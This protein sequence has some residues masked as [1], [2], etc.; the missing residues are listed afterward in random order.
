MSYLNL[1]FKKPIQNVKHG[2]NKL[3]PS[4]FR[5]VFIL[6][7][8]SAIIAISFVAFLSRSPKTTLPITE[9]IALKTQPSTTNKETIPIPSNRTKTN[10]AIA[11]VVEKTPTTKFSTPI[12]EK[13]SPQMLPEAIPLIKKSITIKNGDTL[14]SAFNNQGISA[15]VLYNVIN[16][17]KDGRLLKSIRQGEKFDFIFKENKLTKLLY[18]PDITQTYSFSKDSSGKFTSKLNTN[19][20]DATPVYREGVIESSLFVAAANSNI[21]VNIIMNMVGIFGWDIDFSL[22]IRKGDHF[23]IIY[24]ELYQ[25]GVKIKT[26]VILAAE[27]TNRGKTYQAVLYTD[28]KND[29]NYYSPDGKSMRKAFLRN[30]VKFSRISSRFTT[31]RWHPVLSKWRSHKGVDYAA[32]RGT[33]IYAAGDGKIIHAG[34]KGG[35]GN[36]VIIKHG[37]KYTTLYAHMN[38]FNKNVRKGRRI[39]QGQTIG[40]VGSTGLVT[41]PHLHYEFRV[42]GVHR[43]P[44]TVK[45]PAAQ[46]INKKYKSDFDINKDKLLNMLNVMGP[47]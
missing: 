10:I 18:H 23:K 8:I 44:L 22:D 11:P 13:K 21:P 40:Y 6:S 12:A 5:P 1:D 9:P 19:P 20:L 32:S 3:F 38:S 4:F 14:S 16:D 34:R 31:K 37:G 29:S 24:N 43:N 42:S 2:K 7:I 47:T 35:Y 45:L 25:D 36:T 26:G 46:P 27:F 41:G 33:P 28:P 15:S 30:P 17:S 39:K